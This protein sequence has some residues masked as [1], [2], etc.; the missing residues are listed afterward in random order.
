[1]HRIG[2]ALRPADVVLLLTSGNL[3]GLIERVALFC[4]EKFPG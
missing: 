1:M 4:E 2:D 3:G